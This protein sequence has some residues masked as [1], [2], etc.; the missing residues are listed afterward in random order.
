MVR[1]RSRQGAEGGGTSPTFKTQVSSPEARGV[2]CQAG[3]AASSWM[4]LQARGASEAERSAKSHPG[5]QETAEEAGQ[6][7]ME[8]WR[9]A[10]AE[11]C[12]RGKTDGRGDRFK[13]THAQSTKCPFSWA[14]VV[15]PPTNQSPSP[16]LSPPGSLESRN[17]QGNKP[18]PCS[19]EDHPETQPT[20]SQDQNK[21]L[22]H[23]S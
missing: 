6:K 20:A 8:G 11:R 1:P 12:S 13:G 2:A 7:R 10:R 17:H 5:H 21:A 23:P 18:Q 22:P 16:G 9:W 3:D 15:Q 4:E 19:R 14:T